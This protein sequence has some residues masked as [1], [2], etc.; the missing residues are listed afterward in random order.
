M[1]ILFLCSGDYD[2]FVYEGSKHYSSR[3]YG[4]SIDCGT[5]NIK[6]ATTNV[7]QDPKNISFIYVNRDGEVVVY[8]AGKDHVMPNI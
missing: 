4:S 6:L 8:S 5:S 2:V 7:A 3:I 1:A